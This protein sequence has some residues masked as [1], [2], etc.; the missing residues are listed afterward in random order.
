MKR[1]DIDKEMEKYIAKFIKDTC[2]SSEDLSTKECMKEISTYKLGLLDGVNIG[3][4]YVIKQLKNIRLNKEVSDNE[5][6][7]G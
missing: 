5:T 3:I 4:S 7:I 6:K 1:E 2:L